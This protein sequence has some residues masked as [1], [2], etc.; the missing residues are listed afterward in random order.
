ML[1][2]CGLSIGWSSLGD[3]QLWAVDVG[4]YWRSLH[5]RRQ[6]CSGFPTILAE[7]LTDAIIDISWLIDMFPG[8][9]IG[10]GTSM[11]CI[12]RWYQAFPLAR[13]RLGKGSIVKPGFKGR[14]SILSPYNHNIWITQP[15]A[16]HT[17]RIIWPKVRAY[18]LY[19]IP[20]GAFL[21]QQ[22]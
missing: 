21:L 9:V 7:K 22:W 5:L 6:G 13:G 10:S 15:C 2:Q 17:E 18:V 19:L 11:G 8:G 12:P 14:Y 3:L 4:P 20:Q 16:F 1:V